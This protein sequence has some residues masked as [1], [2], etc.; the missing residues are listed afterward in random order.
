VSLRVAIGIAPDGSP[1]EQ[2][3]APKIAYLSARSVAGGDARITHHAAVTIAASP[4]AS[5]TA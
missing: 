5:S 3:L 4:V 1:A 2:M